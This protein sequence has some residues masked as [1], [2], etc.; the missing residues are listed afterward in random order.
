MPMTTPFRRSLQND[1]KR[2]GGK[3]RKGNFYE[4]LKLPT[5]T[6]TPF[7]LI[8]AEYVDSNP[9][10]EEIEIDAATGRPKEVKKEYYRFLEHTRQVMKNGT[11]RFPKSVC[12]AGTNPHSPQP[13]AGCAAIDQG[14]R[15]VSPASY[16]TVMGIV[17]L[18]LYHKHPL[19][20][21][22][23]G[24]I[25]M[26]QAYGNRPAEPMMIDNECEG[27]TCNF[28]RVQRN[29]APIIDPQNPWPNYRPQDIQT[30]FG[31]RRYLKMGKNHLQ[32]LIG[33]DATIS[34]LCGNDGS[35]LITDGFKCPSCQ[36]MVIDMTQDTRTDEQ[37]KE[38][39][40]RPY[41]CLRCN[42]PVFLEEVV[43]CE[44]CETANRQPAQHTMF[45]RVLW[46]MR[47]GEQTA[48]TLVLHRHEAIQEFFA[49]VPAPLLGNKTPDALLAELAKPYDFAAL[50]APKTLSE[51]M[52]ELD[53]QGNGPAPAQGYQQA[54]GG[55]QQAPMQQ[56]GPP[57][58]QGYQQ[59]PGAYPA[60]QYPP[61]GPPPA[62]GPAAPQPM[63]QPNFG[64]P[65]GT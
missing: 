37:I 39:V 49:R 3:G 56:M 16:Q 41:P 31:K 43:A 33:W 23:T 10:P 2:T 5:T 48:S 14:D 61:V 1:T 52:K 6:S 64:R 24:G 50:F 54:P 45:S 13:C 60:Q 63:M 18:A 65:P 26:K 17:H 8:K 19:L 22:R 34:S 21:R 9:A 59:A 30:F 4:Q 27:R 12:S 32:A 25:V 51:Q 62:P 47:Q 42:R 20:D 15:S 38:A 11:E 7:I 55:Y 58:G 36:S 29:E 53:L 28:C 40:S 44:V 46:G 35:Q 57:P